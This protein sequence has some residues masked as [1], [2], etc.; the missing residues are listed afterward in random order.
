MLISYYTSSHFSTSDDYDLCHDIFVRDVS[1]VASLAGQK[2][3][4]GPRLSSISSQHPSR[5]PASASAQSGYIS[6]QSSSRSGSGEEARDRKRHRK[7]GRHHDR[8][9]REAEM[10]KQIRLEQKMRE[11]I[12][13]ESY[14]LKEIREGDEVG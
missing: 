11:Y 4:V 5:L 2:H 13:Q 12:L 6:S 9:S 14:D 7:L 10:G 3:P 8:G 1:S